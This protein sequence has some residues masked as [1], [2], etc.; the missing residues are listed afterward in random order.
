ME[1]FANV[2]SD[3]ADFQT[4]VLRYGSLNGRSGIFFSSSARVFGQ[5]FA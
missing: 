2:V 4:T 3:Y 5:R 1:S